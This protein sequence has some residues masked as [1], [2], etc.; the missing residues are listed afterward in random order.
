MIVIYD[1]INPFSV[2]ERNKRQTNV[3]LNVR[4]NTVGY[5]ES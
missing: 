1:N 5:V 4:Q 2:E 3:A